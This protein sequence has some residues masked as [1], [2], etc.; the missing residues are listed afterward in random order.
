MESTDVTLHVAAEHI[1]VIVDIEGVAR[2]GGTRV[3]P[4]TIVRAF[5]R[6]DTA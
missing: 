5:K 4:D 2:V 3:T 6:G 1:P